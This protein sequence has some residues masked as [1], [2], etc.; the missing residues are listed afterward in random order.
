MN[1]LQFNNF[2]AYISIELPLYYYNIKGY[3]FRPFNFIIPGID[4]F[5]VLILRHYKKQRGYLN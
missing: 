4:F 3:N 5:M 1:S 2:W